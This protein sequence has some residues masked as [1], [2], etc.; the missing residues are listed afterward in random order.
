MRRAGGG[1]AGGLGPGG[2]AKCPVASPAV[3]RAGE[4]VVRGK[5]EMVLS[6]KGGGFC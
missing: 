6:P 2:S 5:A 1:L 3:G 4:S